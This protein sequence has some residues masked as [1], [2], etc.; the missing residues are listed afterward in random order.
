MLLEP[1]EGDTDSFAMDINDAG[2]IVGCSSRSVNGITIETGIVRRGRWLPQD[3]ENR[4]TVVVAPPLAGTSAH[5]A[6]RSPL[7]GISWR[8]VGLL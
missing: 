6:R 2:I 4:G 7:P 8:T 5:A 1:L 3:E